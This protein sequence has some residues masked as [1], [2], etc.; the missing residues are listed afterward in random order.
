MDAQSHPK[1]TTNT[2][3][4]IGLDI[5]NGAYRCWNALYNSPSVAAT[6]CD[7]FFLPT[8]IQQQI[9][10]RLFCGRHQPRISQETGGKRVLHFKRKTRRPSTDLLSGRV[11]REETDEAGNLQQKVQQKGHASVE[12]ESFDGWHTRQSTCSGRI[13]KI[14]K[15]SSSKNL[16]RKGN[17]PRKKQQDSDTDDSNMDGAT[18]PTMRPMCSACDSSGLR[19]SR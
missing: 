6:L 17:R 13:K 18:S 14:F 10:S 15:S 2:T 16:T 1:N 7:S 4:L 11:Q 8:W 3:A 9:S 12:S 19:G 5:R